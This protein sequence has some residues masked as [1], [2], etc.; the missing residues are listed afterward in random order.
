MGQGGAHWKP[1]GPSP[2]TPTLAR[3]A[4]SF[5]KASSP[6]RP[7]RHWPGRGRDLRLP[8]RHPMGT[9]LD[10]RYAARSRHARRDPAGESGYN[11]TDHRRNHRLPMFAAHRRSLGQKGCAVCLLSR[12]PTRGSDDFYA[13]YGI[14]PR[15][16]R[17]P[18]YGIFRLWGNRRFRDLF[19][20][21]VSDSHPRHGAR[22][23]F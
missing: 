5:H 1:L 2:P 6:R 3:K 12:R 9:E 15:G 21:I 17:L 4:G 7:N 13:G 14:Q 11:D 16:P 10:R 19:S 23:L 18:D 22:L 20:R 8:R